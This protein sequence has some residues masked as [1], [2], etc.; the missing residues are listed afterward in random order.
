MA[1]CHADCSPHTRWLTVTNGDNAYDPA[2]WHEVAAGPPHAHVLAFDF[3]SRYQRFTGAVAPACSAL[4]RA[5][6]V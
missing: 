2:F 6:A 4:P 1:T 3:Y 5:R